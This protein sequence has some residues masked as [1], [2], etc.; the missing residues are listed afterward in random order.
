MTTCT[1]HRGHMYIESP[2]TRCQRKRGADDV[3]W[4]EADTGF[5]EQQGTSDRRFGCHFDTPREDFRGG[6]HIEGKRGRPHHR[7]SNDQQPEILF[8][9]GCHFLP[10]LEHM[11]RLQKREHAGD[12]SGRRRDQHTG[13]ILFLGRSTHGENY[14]GG[15]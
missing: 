7:L 9:V 15:W 14:R 1:F 2:Q 13:Q 4:R 5:V 8:K 6:T 11:R 10:H 12:F 3:F